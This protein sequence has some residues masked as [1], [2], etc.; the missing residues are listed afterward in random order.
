VNLLVNF[1][2]TLSQLEPAFNELYEDRRNWRAR[3]NGILELAREMKIVWDGLE[4]LHDRCIQDENE[5]TAVKVKLTMSR[6]NAV[7]NDFKEMFAINRCL[8]AEEFFFQ[9]TGLF[10]YAVSDLFG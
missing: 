9:A 10:N 7:G 6:L 1:K 8:V 4:K 2:A 5:D 3:K